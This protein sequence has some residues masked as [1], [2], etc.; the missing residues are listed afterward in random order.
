M[1]GS[2][3]TVVASEARRSEDSD[4]SPSGVSRVRPWLSVVLHLVWDASDEESSASAEI[5][6]YGWDAV[7]EA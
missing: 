1:R 4:W 3:V 7:D 2:C 6:D 5:L